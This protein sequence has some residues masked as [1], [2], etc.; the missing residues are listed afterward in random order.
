MDEIFNVLSLISLLLGMLG[1]TIQRV[2]GECSAKDY[3]FTARVAIVASVV[4]SLL[5]QESAFGAPYFAINEQTLSVYALTSVMVYIW[6]SLSLKWF[7]SENLPSCLFC[8]LALVAL[9]CCRVLAA[10]QNLMIIFAAL[11]VLMLINYLFLY[12]SQQTEELHNISSRYGLSALLFVFVAGI[13]LYLLTPKGW[14]LAQAADMTIGWGLF[15]TYIVVAGFLFVFMFM[16]AIAP[17]HFWF[18]DTIAPAVLPVAAYLSLV[19]QL[20]LWTA[21]GN[22]HHQ[23]LQP[24]MNNINDLYVLFGVL[25]I[26]AGA[27][28]AN[29][30][31]NLRKIFAGC[32]VY[33]FGVI[34]LVFAALPDKMPFDSHAYIQIYLLSMMG[35]Y[36]VFYAFKCRGDYL[37]NLNMIGGFARARPFVAG[38][39]LLFMASLAGLAPMPGFYG[40]WFALEGLANRDFYVLMF[41]TAG[42]LMF[43]LPAYLQIVKAVCFM[44]RKDNFDRTDN[45]IYFYLTLI[46]ALMLGLI[47]KP[48]FLQML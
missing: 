13:A 35:I 3:F 26:L 16:L 28:G 22:V 25:S 8:F 5:F 10:A 30:S 27:V 17:L 31:R 23:F 18:A 29:T 21:F 1:V 32:G 24:I 36:T 19:P 39:M 38:A 2:W 46:L 12:L 6:L 45:N 4:F 44:P 7:V 9:L 40:I 43:L 48:Q 15:K 47:C 37:Y 33:C 14:N 41:V 20:S 34:L 42:C 11:A